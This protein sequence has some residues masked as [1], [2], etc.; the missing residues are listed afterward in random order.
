MHYTLSEN[1]ANTHITPKVL[2]RNVWM[3]TMDDSN[4]Y[5]LFDLFIFI[6]GRRIIIAYSIK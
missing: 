2:L 5:I 4:V 6:V 1:K 3:T